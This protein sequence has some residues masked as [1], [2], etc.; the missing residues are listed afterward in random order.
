MLR[1][2]RVFLLLCFLFVTIGV[3]AQQNNTIK[4]TIEWT[5][6]RTFGEEETSLV[7]PIVLPYFKTAKYRIDESILPE[8]CEREKLGGNPNDADVVLSAA[9]YTSLTSQEAKL[10]KNQAIADNVKVDA[11]V[12]YS[13][14]EAYLNYCVQPI[15]KNPLTGQLEKLTSFELTVSPKV[16]FNN[17]TANSR[18]AK[19]AG[20]SVLST[21]NWYKISIEGEGI[22][23][24]DRAFFQQLG[25][26]PGSIDPRNIRIY[27][28]GG[29]MLPEANDEFR[30]DDLQENAIF[31][32]GEADG[33][34]NQNDY[35]L[36]YGQSQHRWRYNSNQ[37]KFRHTYNVY[38]ER[39]FYFI[40]VDQGP[41]KRMANKPQSTNAI[42]DVVTAFDDYKFLE[43]EEENLVGSGR[44]W[45]GEFYDFTNSYNFPFNFPNT[46]ATEDALY[47]I[48][49]VARSSVGGTFMDIRYNGTDI[50]E[51]LSFAPITST[52]SSN[53]VSQSTIFDTLNL[54]STNTDNIT[55]TISYDNSVN[56]SA[57]AWMDYVEM[58]VRRELNMSGIGQRAQ[59]F[60]RDQRSVGTSNTASYTISNVGTNT[61]V[62]DVTDPTNVSVQSNTLTGNNLTF[63]AD[64]D[65]LREYVAFNQNSHNNFPVPTVIGAV[66][67][68]NLHAL[69]QVDFV[70]VT[71]PS[72]RSEANRLAEFHRNEDNMNVA[73]VTTTE[74]YNEFSSGA[75]D[76]TAIRDFMRMLYKDAAIP[77]DAPKYLLLF[78][79][80]SYDYKDIFPDNTN[81][82][83]VY[84]SPASFTLYTS[85]ATDDYYGFLD[86][87]EGKNMIVELLDVGIGRFPVKSLAE[88]KIAVDKALNYASSNTLGDWRNE[89][90]FVADDVDQGWETLLIGGA[91]D[92]AQK[93]E[94]RHKE[95][96]VNKIYLD[97]YVQ[98]SG[99]GGE[100]YPSASEDFFRK[101]QRGAL[102]AS[103]VGHGGE[104]GWA[105]ERVLELSHVNSWT[106]YNTT[107]IFV[108]ITCEFSRYDDPLR[109]SAGEQA[110]LS[111]TGAAAA[112]FSTT[113]VVF[114]S[115]A[116]DLNRQFFDTVF[117]QQNGQYM[118][119]GE[120]I[121]AAKNSQG[122]DAD[123]LN[124]A[125]IGDPAMRMAVP[126]YN[127]VTTTIN[128]NNVTGGVTD[129]I[130]ALSFV[131]IT[132]EVRDD[133]DQLM[134]NFNG[135]VTPAVYDKSKVRTT[136]VN[137][138]VGPAIDYNSQESVL[139]KGKV[140]VVNG[141]FSFSFVV[142]RDISF[143]VG[144]GR[145]SYYAENGE[146]DAAGYFEDFIVAGINTD[147]VN[148]NNGPE[149]ELFMNDENF[150][151][152]GLTDEDPVLLAK[153]IDS[154]GVNTVGN[155]IGHDIIATL[156]EDTDQQEVLN[157]FFEADLNSY[158]SGTIRFPYFNIEA[159]RHTLSLRIWDVHNN[160]GVS[161]TE[162]I[163]AESAELALE[164]ILNY[165]N[166]FTTYTE[167]QFEHNR[168]NEPLQVQVQV[169][170]VSGK[171]VKTLNTTVQSQGTRITPIA[172]DGLDDY[173]DK[174]GR[175]VYI[176]RLRVRSLIDNS[177][178]EEYE[179]LVILR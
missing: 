41:G 26:N 144:N 116:N 100:R 24:L 32:E 35:V 74:V 40:N 7:K 47:G 126:E 176:Y 136:L 46:V 78:G 3:N 108:T 58:Q 128:G 1:F 23:K 19:A 107:P 90:I 8:F 82:V 49:A 75:Q 98:S 28:N 85:F 167:F 142:P 102:I 150:V 10:L 33:S 39:T 76:I 34:F 161:K 66:P 15:R 129:T 27:G 81:F 84:Q 38:S 36:F 96:N 31:V 110:F 83:P 12:A 30:Y 55:L 160:P 103:W 123:K 53:F 165:P 101:A 57:F 158:Q 173:G 140:E 73:L 71:H 25:L 120:I 131:T 43:S 37:E 20:Q 134:T 95:F 159:G 139:F 113:R 124:F 80:A 169:L 109:V 114:E 135:V 106:N 146:V 92:V 63:I 152:G 93:V 119:M 94:N 172:W 65:E 18:R 132:G 44:R 70:I 4:K 143:T 178:D 67:N 175:G 170:T 91:E 64:A 29:G 163:V 89:V 112:L 133:N 77:D 50:G 168:P 14:G 62:W 59:M 151:F 6:P 177:S 56:P 162:F 9:S 164:R 42:T 122:V 115:S 125:L 54:G 156:D 48:V 147:A 79:D 171:L 11:T 5:N 157:D 22:Y 130:S 138:A 104:V 105:T 2:N 61:K 17:S 99:V 13:R 88:A 68:Q 137:D 51:N 121:M 148:D 45:F 117:T 21:G 111:P 153:V 72:L 52:A 155:G 145:I 141:Q 87:N 118:R 97:S 174:I 154:S 60:F 179:K 149:V 127:V 86:D 166:P 16:T 69:E